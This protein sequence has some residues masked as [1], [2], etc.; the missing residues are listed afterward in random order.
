MTSRQCGAAMILCCLMMA[1]ISARAADGPASG[2]LATTVAT[3][4]ISVADLIEA[5][6]TARSA[7]SGTQTI[8]VM[9]PGR[10]VRILASPG[11]A[12]VRGA[13]LLDWEQ[14]PAARQAWEQARTGS[15]LAAQQRA[16]M[17]LLLTHHLGTRDQLDQADKA[18]ADAQAAV[19]ALKRTGADQANRTISAPAD[20]TVLTIPVSQ[21]D[22]LAAGAAL[23]TIMSSGGIVVTVGVDPARRLQ[24]RVGQTAT[25][26]PVAGGTPVA[27]R[28]LRFDAI[29]NPRTRLVNTDLAVA[30]AD[31]LPGAD[32]TA[33][34]AVGML[35]GW[36]A[37]HDAVLQDAAGTYLFQSLGRKAARVPVKVL[38]TRGNV[39]IVSGALSPSARIIVD[40]AYQLSD[41][42]DFR[43][44]AP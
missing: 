44:A 41:G 14:S 1:S 20:G 19:D 31:V 39:D 6:G 17:V 23:A 15:V 18:L 4:S 42:A 21:G 38:A 29:L 12:V 5:Y 22:R 32:Y 10:V 25:I 13:P 3:R 43:E 35:Q 37:P 16:H 34:I 30:P 27:G 26:M 8:S 40:G 33:Q 7:S 2:V 36:R 11:Q 9:E 24:L 28:V